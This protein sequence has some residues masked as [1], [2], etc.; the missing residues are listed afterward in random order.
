MKITIETEVAAPLDR[1][2]R[3]WTTPENIQQ[4]NAATADWHCPKAAIDLREG[5]QF[6]YRMEAKDGSMAF[7]FGGDFTQVVPRQLIEYVMEDQRSVQVEFIA[8]GETVTVRETFE[9][10]SENSGEQQRQGWQAIL[11]NFA[12]HTEGLRS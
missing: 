8:N 11:E 3:S 12:R 10:E 7:D 2:W 1:V 6:C 4:W 9:A 5:G